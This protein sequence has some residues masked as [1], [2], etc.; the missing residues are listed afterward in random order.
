MHIK[1]SGSSVKLIL[2][3]T[4][5][6]LFSALNIV[7]LSM[8]I[9]ENIVLERLIVLSVLFVQ[10]SILLVFWRV[11]DN[12]VKYST[13]LWLAH[14]CLSIFVL[15]PEN[16][17]FHF[18]FF[19]IAPFLNFIDDFKNNY[20][21]IL[22]L[23]S[24]V[25]YNIAIVYLTFA[26]ISKGVPPDLAI[27]GYLNQFILGIVLIS[28]FL[29][30]FRL[31]RASL[32]KVSREATMDS[33]TKTYNRRSLE[34]DLQFYHQNNRGR[35]AYLVMMDLDNFKLVNDQFGHQAGD[36]ILAGVVDIVKPIVRS[37]DKLYRYGGEEFLLIVQDVEEPGAIG[38]AEKIRLSFETQSW[39]VIK[40]ERLTCSF[41]LAPL[42]G[43]RPIKDS[44]DQADR[45][46]YRAKT[47]GKNRVCLY[48]P[49][50]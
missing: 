8:G 49:I 42:L 40:G 2:S 29:A 38:V 39:D 19:A 4:I 9:V 17:V 22:S 47:T 25:L 20:S 44:I 21:R 10:L 3:R 26:D 14:L 48:I 30:H 33:L 31:N 50:Q 15:Q 23:L 7:Y 34:A 24:L 45:A 1:T 32:E 16:L 37:V 27:V 6:L 18:Y 28:V 36:S 12:L 41:G 13:L 43:N 46:L 5:I 11:L 35:G